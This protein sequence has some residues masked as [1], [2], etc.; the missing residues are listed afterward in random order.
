MTTSPITLR[1]PSSLPSTTPTPPI[2]APTLAFL[3]GT[4]SVTHSTL[5]MWRKNRNVQITYTAIANTSPPHLDDL[6]TYQPLSSSSTKTV[7]GVDKPFAV[8]GTASPAEADAREQRASLA[9]NWRGKG[10]LAIASSRWEVLGYGEE[11]GGNAWV[12]TYFAKTLFTPVGVDFY[13]RKG[14]LKAETVEGIKSALRAMGDEVEKLAG[15]VFEVKMDG[16]KG[17]A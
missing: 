9:Y 17:D 12:V 13:S 6:V 1:A 7:R 2:P 15:D 14:A 8:P 3:S 16:D 5:P 11:E 4:W 10:W